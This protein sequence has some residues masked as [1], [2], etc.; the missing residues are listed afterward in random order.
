[1]F[2]VFVEKYGSLLALSLLKCVDLFLC[3]HVSM[4]TEVLLS[5]K[6]PAARPG[7]A[8]PRVHCDLGT[9]QTWAVVCLVIGL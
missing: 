8:F 9:H 3:L 7:H 6:L 2:V 4:W 1:M 5:A